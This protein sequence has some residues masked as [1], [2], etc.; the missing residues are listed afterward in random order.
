MFLSIKSLRLVLSSLEFSMVT[1]LTLVQRTK[2]LAPTIKHLAPAQ[3]VPSPFSSKSLSKPI[4]KYLNHQN[5]TILYNF[6]LSCPKSPHFRSATWVPSV[7]TTPSGSTTPASSP[8]TPSMG[9]R[10]WSASR[11]AGCATRGWRKPW[12]CRR[13]AMCPGQK[14]RETEEFTMKNYGKTGTTM[15]SL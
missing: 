1:L 8:P 2:K 11:R 15:V 9:P 14:T 10:A 12:R 3:E 13:A 6:Y 4:V 7:A 5:P